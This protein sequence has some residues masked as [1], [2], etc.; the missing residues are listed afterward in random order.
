MKY[1]ALIAGLSDSGS[2]EAWIAAQPDLEAACKRIN[3]RRVALGLVSP[4]SI[5]SDTE[6]QAVFRSAKGLWAA[7]FELE[8]AMAPLR[9]R[10]GMGIGEITT[11]INDREATGMEGE[12]FENAQA[13]FDSLKEKEVG[14]EKHFRIKGLGEEEML[15]QHAL[16]LVSYQRNSWRNN[17]VATFL[18]MLKG[19]SAQITA[20]KLSTSEQAVYRNIRDGDLKTVQGL[21]AELSRLMG[22]KLTN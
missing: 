17:R 20:E 6:V 9:L 8:L 5:T 18:G 21:L 4:F 19:E 2:E 13:S 10:Y 7:I 11:R 15:A 14:K 3:Q 22:E 12:A 16:D 1:I